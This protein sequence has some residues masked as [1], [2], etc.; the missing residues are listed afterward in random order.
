MENGP[1]PSLD[2]TYKYEYKNAETVW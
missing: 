2:S 1:T